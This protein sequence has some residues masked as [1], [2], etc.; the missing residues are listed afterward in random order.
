MVDHLANIGHATLY[1][2]III[3]RFLPSMVAAST[4]F[5]LS[6]FPVL[7]DSTGIKWGMH[8]PFRIYKPD[9]NGPLQNVE[10]RGTDLMLHFCGISLYRIRTTM[11]YHVLTFLG[12]LHMSQ[13]WFVNPI[14]GGG[15][16]QQNGVETFKKAECTPFFSMLSW[17]IKL[18]FATWFLKSFDGNKHAIWEGKRIVTLSYCSWNPTDSN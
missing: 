12:H 17:P 5:E 3:L 9:Q 14:E 2:A 16:L 15:V 11:F 1:C 13:I 6:H 8:P 7:P 18:R 4:P 10:A